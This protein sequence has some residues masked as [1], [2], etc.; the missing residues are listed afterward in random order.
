[1]S[2]NAGGEENEEG[3]GVWS[4]HA[5]LFKSFGRVGVKKTIAFTHDNDITCSVDYE[6]SSVL[7]EGTE[8]SIERYDITGV[9]K[10]AKEMAEKGLAKPKVSLQFE[11]SSSGLSQLVKAEAAVEEMIMVTEEVEMDDDEEEEEGVGNNTATDA[12]MPADDEKEKEEA[13]KKDEEATEKKEDSEKTEEDKAVPQ[14]DDEE[15]KEGKNATETK[16]P[17]KK[18]TKTIEKVRINEW[19]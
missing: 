14:G 18:K 12:E 16:K 11:M 13:E 7:P 3:D 1:M 8:S 17:K 4:K 10:F 5:T 19:R 6:E 15:K 2:A 9:S